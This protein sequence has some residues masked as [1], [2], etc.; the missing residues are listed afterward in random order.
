MLV[1]ELITITKSS[2][3]ARC[4]C[5]REKYLKV[6]WA[7]ANVD[8]KLVLCSL[9]ELLGQAA[10]KRKLTLDSE[11]V[12][13]LRSKR[14]SNELLLPARLRLASKNKDVAVPSSF[15]KFFEKGDRK[16]YI[17]KCIGSW[18]AVEQVR[19]NEKEKSALI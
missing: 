11:M 6:L 16:R 15:L 4:D 18:E 10:K 8:F 13:E 2:D 3:D 1:I 14:H 19:L 9:S 5:L 17:D 7:V 12:R